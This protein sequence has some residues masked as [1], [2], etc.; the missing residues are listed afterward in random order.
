MPC[1]CQNGRETA[2]NSG[3]SRAPRTASD[4]GIG[5]LTRCVKHTSKQRVAGSNPAERATRSSRLTCAYLHVGFGSDI[6]V[7]AGRVPG[8]SRFGAVD[9]PGR[10]GCSGQQV[11]F[12]VL[13]SGW[14][15]GVRVTAAG[16]VAP[17]LWRC[18][19]GEAGEGLA[20]SAPGFGGRPAAARRASS[21]WRASQAVRMR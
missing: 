19:G 11:V 12:S 9:H 10:C 3:R 21:A 2:V 8:W 6:F 18:C 14:S 15:S 4:L 13:W 20:A 16:R 17:G 5:W 7:R 1:P